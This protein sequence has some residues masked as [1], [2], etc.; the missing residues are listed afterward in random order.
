MKQVITKAC[1]VTVHTPDEL[2]VEFAPGDVIDERD[3][4]PEVLRLLQR[5]RLLETATEAKE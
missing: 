4:H 3:I 5:A 1:R 2:V